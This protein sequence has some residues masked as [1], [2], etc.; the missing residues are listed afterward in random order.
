MDFIRK[1]GNVN[2]HYINMDETK[3]IKEN[4]MI[5]LR[6]QKDLF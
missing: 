2:W 4:N 5:K 3:I 6:P 1:Y